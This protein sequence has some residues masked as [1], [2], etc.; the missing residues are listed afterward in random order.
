MNSVLCGAEG[1]S[2]SEESKPIGETVDA[3]IWTQPTDW[4]DGRRP[5]PFAAKYMI[6]VS[7]EERQRRKS[8]LKSIGFDHAVR[9]MWGNTQEATAL[10]TALNFFWEQDN[11]VVL[12]EVGMCGASLQSNC[13]ENGGLLVGA[14]PDGLLCYPD[15]RV[16]VLEVKNHC[17]FYSIQGGSRKGKSSPRRTNS[18]RFSIRHFRFD[19]TGV[20][21]HYVP[22]LMMEMLCVGPEC[23]SAVMV[24]QTATTGALVLRIKRDDGWIDE[25]MYWL[26]RFQA[27]FVN[28]GVAPPENFFLNGTST[29]H[30]RYLKFLNWTKTL[31]SKVELLG[32]VHNSKVQRAMGTSPGTTDF[33]LD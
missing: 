27:D 25:M 15:G 10:L 14:T 11:E 4:N 12:K 32:H 9:M 6:K 2:N 22:Q 21:P 31:E 8:V 30:T 19:K 24:R 33:F 18:K 28:R 16:E 13:T 29:D 3:N 7:K 1:Y 23:Q 5:F 17:P 26:N 20:L